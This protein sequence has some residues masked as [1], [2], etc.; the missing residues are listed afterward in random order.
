[1]TAFLVIIGGCLWC[2]AVVAVMVAA[3][4]AAMDGSRLRGLVLGFVAMILF[5][6]PF[7]V[8]SAWADRDAYRNTLCLRGHE[9]W[10]TSRRGQMHKIWVCEEWET[11]R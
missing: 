2:A 6:A 9:Q 8:I 11:E 7:G 10:V 3:T 1:M 5:A 4:D